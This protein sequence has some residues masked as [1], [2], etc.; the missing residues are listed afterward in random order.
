MLVSSRPYREGS[1]VRCGTSPVIGIVV[2]VVS[3]RVLVGAE[4]VQA[5][6]GRVAG[7]RREFLPGDEPALPPERDQLPDRMTITGNGER[8]PV[9]NGVHDLP[10]P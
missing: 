5:A 8:L 7:H 3:G 1:P 9:F 2:L 6:L 4:R 10:R